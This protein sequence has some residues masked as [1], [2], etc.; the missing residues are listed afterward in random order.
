M[1]L[2]VGDKVKTLVAIKA[3]DLFSEGVITGF[4]P[5]HCYPIEVKLK[6]CYAY[7]A[8]HELDLI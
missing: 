7:F 1:S 2:G 4:Q 3:A 6:N 8:E 5:K